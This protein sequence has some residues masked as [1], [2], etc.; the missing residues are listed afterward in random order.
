MASVRV[1]VAP[2]EYDIDH[3]DGVAV[4]ITQ[5]DNSSLKKSPQTFRRKQQHRNSLNRCKRRQM[6]LGHVDNGNTYHYRDNLNFVIISTPM[7]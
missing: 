7:H 3:Q 4:A 6:A 1:P 5:L 2:A